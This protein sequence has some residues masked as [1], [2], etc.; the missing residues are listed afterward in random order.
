MWTKVVWVISGLLLAIL[1]IDLSYSCWVNLSRVSWERSV[2]RGQNGVR[3]GCDSARMGEGRTAVLMVHGF[4]DSPALWGR[5]MP[6]LADRGY[7]CR[8]ILLPGF[9]VPIAQQ[10]AATLASW[11]EEV[12]LA[13]EELREQ[14]DSLWI[15]A[16]S[17]GAA[18]TLG[19]I[20]DEQIQPDGLVLV[21]PLV[22]VSTERS[23]VLKPASWFRIASAISPFTQQ[24]KMLFPVDAQDPVVWNSHPRDLFVTKNIYR[25]LFRAV[26]RLAEVTDLKLPPTL[27]LQAGKDH[28]VDNEAM[29]EFIETQDAKTLESHRM[30][31]SGHL[32]PLDLDCN[33]AATLLL[34]FLKRFDESET[35]VL[36]EPPKEQ[37]R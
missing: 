3:K 20:A 28:V 1:A 26:N 34:D 12:T 22:E 9:A 15:V 11:R 35:D 16:H 8:S 19:L 37:R 32:L 23:P 25:D 6:I 7:A 36:T 21:A 4:A 33:E 29:T 31:R 17:L 30:E 24:V 27:L 18:I 13:L 5:W 10:K 14:H 2:D